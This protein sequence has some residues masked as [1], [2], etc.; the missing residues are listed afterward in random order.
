MATSL[1]DSPWASAGDWLAELD[2]L[3]HTA[4]SARNLRSLDV[5]QWRQALLYLFV[6]TILTT[7]IARLWLHPLK[8]IPGPWIAAVTSGY[9]FYYNVIRDGTYIHQF[10]RLH[11]EYSW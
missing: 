5:S 4:I 2:E 1:V 3:V 6:L 7:I 9:D 8:K 10:P 11:K